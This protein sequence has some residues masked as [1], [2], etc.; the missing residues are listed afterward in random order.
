M[1]D[2]LK[3]AY[4]FI[5]IKVGKIINLLVK[6][7]TAYVVV[8][9]AVLQVASIVVENV[10][11]QEIFGLS[12]ESLMQILLVLIPSGL[13]IALLLAYI[14]KSKKLNTVPIDESDT[15][16][17]KSKNY[18]QKVGVV[19]FE[20]L[21]DDSDGEFLVDGI[22]E[23]LITEL[24]M[25]KEISVATRKTCFE[26]KG[27]NYTAE[28]LMHQLGLDYL[29]SGS[30]RAVKD[31]L[32]ISVELSDTAENN[33][34]WSNKYDR[35]KADV[36]D[37]Q[38]EIVTKIINSMIGEIELNSLKRAHRK[39][40]ENMTSYECTLRGRALNQKFEKNAN[41][42]AIKML[43]AAIEA[44]KTNPLPYS[45]KAC[46]IGQALTLG[47]LE[48]TDDVMANFGEALS[49]ANELNDNDWNANRIL[50]EAHLTFHDYL[51]TKI[52]ATKAYNANPNNPHVLSI[53]GNALLR[54]GEIDKGIKILEKMYELEPVVLAD[55]NS[56][57]QLA[58][59]FFAHY[60]NDDFGKCRE[61]FKQISEPD[62][63]T[64][65]LF[66]D[67]LLR[68]GS[69]VNGESWFRAGVEKFREV[70][71][72]IEIDRF[73]LNDPDAQ[74]GFLQLSERLVAA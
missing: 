69:E 41:A 21:N 46:T 72:A 58:A 60:L 9:F 33:V 42:E 16:E 13:P 52:Y 30:I 24:S 70:D 38:D 18:K 23:D 66:S 36:F 22:V 48:R 19:P 2:K 73:H 34:I 43:D 40:T 37:I 4:F 25:I 29:V 6:T 7:A 53:Y 44:D 26:L 3:T 71:W 65:L 50:A 67:I 1:S 64:W 27:T 11:T 51:K 39:S 55:S 14:S 49:K 10:S 28:G 56:D 35:I 59:L 15:A 20:N 61:I 57:R 5:K 45:W 68:E 47:F 63:R 8:G 31:K 74:K 17:F 12:S 32:R 62:L 54:T